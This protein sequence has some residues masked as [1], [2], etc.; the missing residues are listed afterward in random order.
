MKANIS[1]PYIVHPVNSHEKQD[2]IMQNMYN[3]LFKRFMRNKQI[4]EQL[5]QSNCILYMQNSKGIE[6]ITGIKNI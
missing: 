3:R 5:K 6:T 1:N 2:L 4:R